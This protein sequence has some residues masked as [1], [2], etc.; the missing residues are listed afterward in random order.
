MATGRF[1]I[2]SGSPEFLE[3]VFAENHIL[4]VDRARYRSDQLRLVERFAENACC[5]I[6]PI[7]SKRLAADENVGN[8]P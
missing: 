2:Y 5:G 4:W 3:V 6:E 8:K 1:G 7:R